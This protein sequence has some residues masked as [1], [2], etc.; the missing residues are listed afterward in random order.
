MRPAIN[1]AGRRQGA[2]IHLRLQLGEHA[3]L[4]GRVALVAPVPAKRQIA[5]V[6]GSPLA[7][8]A[9]TIMRLARRASQAVPAPG[10]TRSSHDTGRDRL[11]HRHGQQGD[12][13]AR[14][15]KRNKTKINTFVP[16]HGDVAGSHGQMKTQLVST[17]KQAALSR[18]RC[19][20]V[21]SNNTVLCTRTMACFACRLK[22][23]LVVLGYTVRSVSGM[24]RP[25][26]S[27]SSPSREKNLP[28]SITASH[29]CVLLCRDLSSM[30][31]N[32]LAAAAIARRVLLAIQRDIAA[33]RLTTAC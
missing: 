23:S 2:I 31:C 8:T 27:V 11:G 13:R 1:R 12:C 32:L 29:V 3:L 18:G 19:E 10:W 16:T 26:V 7:R 30:A 5:T 15:G 20:G 28:T 25:R 21:P 6:V 22:S 9:I 17:Q 24:P 4:Q 14:G 33:G